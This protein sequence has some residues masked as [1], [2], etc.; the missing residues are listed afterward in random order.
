MTHIT[1]AMALMRQDELRREASALRGT[2]S[3]K[4]ARGALSL[5]G[6]YRR[7]RVRRLAPVTA[8]RL[9]L[10]PLSRRFF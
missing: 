8:E 1:Y 10:Y 4:R 5:I 3:A 6:A 7:R 2:D 9:R